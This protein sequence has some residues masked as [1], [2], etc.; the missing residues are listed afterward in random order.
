[1][2]P[3]YDRHGRKVAHTQFGEVLSR[4]TAARDLAFLFLNGKIAYIVW[5]IVGDDF[6]VANWMFE[7]FPFVLSGLPE[8]AE[9]VLRSHVAQLERAIED[10]LCFKK[11]A[12]KEVGN[13]NLALCRHVTDRTDAVFAQNFGMDHAWQDIELMCDQMVRTDFI[14][15]ESACPRDD[16]PQTPAESE[17]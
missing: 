14:E 9:R 4:G 10:A 8:D 11:N 16:S 3:C 15:P 5:A 1:M 12:G 6:H 13:Y 2:P 7:S 17:H